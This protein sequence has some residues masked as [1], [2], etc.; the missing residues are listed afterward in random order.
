MPRN[1]SNFGLQR[2]L[3]NDGNGWSKRG[4]IGGPFAGV[5]GHATRDAAEPVWE[6]NTR[7]MHVRR[8]VAQD[9]VTFRTRSAIIWTPT[10]YDAIDTGDVIAVPV[11]GLA[12]DVN[13]TVIEKIPERKPSAR[14]GPHLADT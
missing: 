2:Y 1:Q 5:D 7:R 13:Y 3:D 12:T 10:A 9:A 6:K 4:E 11:T 14:L 8:V